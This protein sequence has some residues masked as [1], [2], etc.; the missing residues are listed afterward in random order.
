MEEPLPTVTAIDHNAVCAAHVVKFK[1]NEVGTR[2]TDALP[3]Q[4]SSGVF[5]LCDT[6]LCKACLLYTSRCV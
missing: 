3:T 1:G 4:T 6:L 5:A 2:P